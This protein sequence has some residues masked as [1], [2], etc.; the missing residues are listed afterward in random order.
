MPNFQG[1]KFDYFTIEDDPEGGGFAVYGHGTYDRRSVLEGQHRRCFIECYPTQAD[2]KKDF[3]DAEEAN[4]RPF[5]TGD[6]S[7]ADLSGLPECPP[8]DFDPADAGERWDDDY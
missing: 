5:R 3:P 1:E 8:H 4:T 2:A 6:E 7:L